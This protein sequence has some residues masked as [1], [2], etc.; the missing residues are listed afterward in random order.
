MTFEQWWK[1]NE[2]LMSKHVRLQEWTYLRQDFEDAWHDG[3]RIGFELGRK[4]GRK[5]RDE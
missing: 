2:Q 3:W 1:Q 5:K 4:K